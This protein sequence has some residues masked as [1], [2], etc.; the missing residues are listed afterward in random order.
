MNRISKYRAKSKKTGK[1]VFGCLIYNLDPSKAVD[2][3]RE[4]FIREPLGNLSTT[5]EVDPETIGEFTGC[6]D[7]KKT[8]IYED[9]I[10]RSDIEVPETGSSEKY[11]TP[12]IWDN[13]EFRT[14]DFS[15][16]YVHCSNELANVDCEIIGNMHDNPKLAEKWN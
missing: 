12:I 13:G 5:H 16:L 15:P 1:W 10:I 4:A 9:D 6:I 2:T 11:V 7:K 3:I 8:E 14:A